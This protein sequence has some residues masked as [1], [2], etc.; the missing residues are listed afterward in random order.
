MSIKGKKL[1]KLL[2]SAFQE[3]SEK[4]VPP[5]SQ[6]LWTELQQ[7]PEFASLEKSKHILPEYKRSRNTR[8]RALLHSGENT[9]M[10]RDW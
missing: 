1:D 9:G 2:R 5:S 10:Y 7:R 4:I 3:Q 8:E 6:K